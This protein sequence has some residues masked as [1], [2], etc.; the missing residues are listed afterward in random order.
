MSSAGAATTY[1]HGPL[2]IE[3]SLQQTA[4]LGAPLDPKARIL[5]ALGILD[6]L[7][8]VPVGDF[9][10]VHGRLFDPPFVL[11][12]GF[13]AAQTALTER[14]PRHQSAFRRFFERVQAVQEA[15]S[16]VG[17]LHDSLWWFLHASALP[18]KLW[19][20]LRDM[21]LSLAQVFDQLFGDDEAFTSAVNRR[22]RA[23]G[24][25]CGSC[26]SGSAMPSRSSNRSKSSGSASET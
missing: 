18:L 10:Q 25:I 22:R 13:D 9:Y 23:S 19:P 26:T 4:D 16:V 15:I 5:Q 3:G 20:L 6:D 8:F 14:F 12:H 17:E 2:T 11:P 1:R 24:S 21:R 7:D